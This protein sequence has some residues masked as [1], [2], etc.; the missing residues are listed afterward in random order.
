MQRLGWIWIVLALTGAALAKEPVR[1]VLPNGMSV[2]VQETYASPTVSLNVFVRVGSLQETPDTT[3]LAH[4][5]EHMFFRGTPTRSGLDFKKEIESL[6]GITNAS[7]SRDMTHYYINMPSAYAKEGLQL[8]SDAL[9]NADLE[10]AGIDK[11]REVVLEEYRIGEN[12]PARIASDKLF[13]MAFPGHPYGRSVIGDKSNLESYQREKFAFWKSHYYVPSRTCVVV[14]GDVDADQI[15]AEARQLFGS[16]K[17]TGEPAKTFPRPQPPAE[18]VYRTE[19]AP[20]NRSFVLLGYLGPSVHDQPDVVEVD[21]LSFLVGQGKGSLLDKQVVDEKKAFSCDVSFLTQ[22]QPGLIVVAAVADPKKADETRQAVLATIDKVRQG[23][24]TQED[25][26]R[27]KNML[28]NSYRFGNE[29]NSGKASSLGFYETLDKVDFAT[30]Y[31][32]NI[33]KVDKA[34]LVKAANKYFIDNHYGLTLAP[35]GRKDSRS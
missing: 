21:V 8:L 22:S 24:F 33:Q 7:T 16:F 25:I 15:I 4:F 5:Y 18:P 28:I 11:E 27:A 14:V 1:V 32:A 19:T 34:A 20:V 29:S 6:G 17:G 30:H 10:K 31:I 23:E 3:G 9:M 2:I 35:K 26:D 13:E 12:N